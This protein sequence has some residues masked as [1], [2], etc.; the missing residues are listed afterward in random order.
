MP[1][2]ILLSIVVLWYVPAVS[3]HPRLNMS[4][5]TR[6]SLTSRQ[7]DPAILARA[8][9]GR[10]VLAWGGSF[11]SGS[12]PWMLEP[13]PDAVRSEGGLN[14]CVMGPLCRISLEP[15]SAARPRHTAPKTKREV[16]KL[17]V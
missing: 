11:A 8:N 2:R 3:I 13:E 6:L 4:H 14:V 15:T 16:W 1:S 10:Q 7:Q 17:M 12:K 5:W 9:P